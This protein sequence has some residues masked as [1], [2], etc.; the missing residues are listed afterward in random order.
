MLSTFADYMAAKATNQGLREGASALSASLRLKA[1]S[2]TLEP[3]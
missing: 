1:D 3:Y 2:G